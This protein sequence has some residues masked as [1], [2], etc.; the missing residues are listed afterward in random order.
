MEKKEPLY[1]V[2]GMNINTVIMLKCM[3]LPKK[4]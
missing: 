4:I 2:G 1:T 3:E